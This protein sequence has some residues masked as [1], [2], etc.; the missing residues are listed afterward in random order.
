MSIEA[1]ERDGLIFRPAIKDDLSKIL[2]FTDIFLRR[3]WLVTRKYAFDHLNKTWIV[4][5][6]DKLVAWFYMD[7]KRVEQTL[8]NLIV[9]PKYRK[10]KIGS[11]LIEKLSPKIIRSK[12]DQYTGDPTGFYKKLG[13]KVIKRE[14]RKKNILIMKRESISNTSE[15]DNI[16]KLNI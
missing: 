2:G 4:L 5:D 15:N 12:T 7:G 6:G 9:H 14:G 1:F 3:S 10:R 13:Y 16:N 11:I 8:Y